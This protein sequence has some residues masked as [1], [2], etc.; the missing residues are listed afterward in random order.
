MGHMTLTTC[1]S[2]VICHRLRLDIAYL[3]TKFDYSVASAV[4]EICQKFNMGH[5]ILITRSFRMAFDQSRLQY[6]LPMYTCA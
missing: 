4:S 6:S 5:V 1:L 3:Y 2:V